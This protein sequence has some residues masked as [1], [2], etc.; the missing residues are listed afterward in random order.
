MKRASEQSWPLFMLICGLCSSESLLIWGGHLV[1]L[2][3][4]KSKGSK[5]GQSPAPNRKTLTYLLISSFAS[6]RFA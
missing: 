4:A 2:P 5:L 1:S 6:N 3:C